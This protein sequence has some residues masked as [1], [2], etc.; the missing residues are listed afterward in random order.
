MNLRKI[1][2]LACVG[3]LS[4]PFAL[5]ADNPVY[6]PESRQLFIP[7]IDLMNQQGAYYNASLEFVQG[8][9]WRLTDVSR[10][11]D[12]R[13]VE[14]VRVIRTTSFPVQVFLEVE[15]WVS[16]HCGGNLHTSQRRVDDTFE[17][18]IQL[19]ISYG[20][21]L[22]F[23]NASVSAFSW[24]FP[25][26]VYGLKAGEYRYSVNGGVQSSRALPDVSTGVSVGEDHKLT[27]SFIIEADNILK[28]EAPEYPFVISPSVMHPGK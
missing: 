22:M 23:C 1:T 5:Y 17:V 6:L 20:P 13:G 14:K 3:L 18:A 7:A 19:A 8:D 16:G 28:R 26:P 25:L 4:T 24:I 10:G 9:L 12:I 2:L 27:G 21:P 15:G 11:E